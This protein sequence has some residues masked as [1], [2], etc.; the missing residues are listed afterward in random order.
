MAFDD[1]VSGGFTAA[2]AVCY[3]Q[4]G[5]NFRQGFGAA[6]DDFP[7]LSIADSVAQAHVHIWSPRN[8]LSGM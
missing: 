5:L 7:D 2:T 6:I 8:D 4:I 1:L 3:G